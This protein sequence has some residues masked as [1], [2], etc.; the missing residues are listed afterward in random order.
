MTCLPTQ[1]KLAQEHNLKVQKNDLETILNS[2]Q[3]FGKIYGFTEGTLKTLVISDPE[4][5]H[6]VFVT[7]YD[8]FYGRKR[9]PIQGDSE[10]EKRT[11]LFAAQGFRWKRLR[12]ISSP[13]F[14]N[15]SLR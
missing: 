15:S 8:N 12:A 6:E 4:L 7:Q 3:K 14:S 1:K 9:N 10:K 5:V 13:T 11:N 2:F